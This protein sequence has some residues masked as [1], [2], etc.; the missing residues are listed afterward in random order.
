MSQRR[1]HSF[2]QITPHYVSYCAVLESVKS[3]RRFDYGFCSAF[4]CII[5]SQNM[6]SIVLPCKLAWICLVFL[7]SFVCLFVLRE[8]CQILRSGGHP[9]PPPLLS[10]LSFLS[11]IPQV[12][13]LSAH[14][15]RCETERCVMH[16]IWYLQP[17]MHNH[18]P[19]RFIND[20]LVC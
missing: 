20:A 12:F 3:G 10:V 7:F 17:N 15:Q 13:V 2:L 9:R 18:S 6:Y 5:G 4:M 14:C 16:C 11:F 8:L 19:T 1:V